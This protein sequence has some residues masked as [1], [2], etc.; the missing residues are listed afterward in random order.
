MERRKKSSIEAMLPGKQFVKTI[1]GRK[2][3]RRVSAFISSIERPN[4]KQI[5]LSS[6]SKEKAN[7]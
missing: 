4:N 1:N 5:R 7:S 2:L 3:K 6:K